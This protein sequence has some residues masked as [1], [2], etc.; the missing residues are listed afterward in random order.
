MGRSA[1][2]VEHDHVQPALDPAIA[3]L[4][5]EQGA[6]RERDYLWLTDRTNRLVELADGVVEVLPMPTDKHQAILQYLLYALHAL[7][8]RVGRL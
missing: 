7:T 1:P 2:A 8:L 6:W 3:A 5:P 4:L